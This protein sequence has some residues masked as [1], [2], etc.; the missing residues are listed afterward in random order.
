MENVTEV[1]QKMRNRATIESNNSNISQGNEIT[2]SKRYLHPP[3]HHV[4]RKVLFIIAKTQ[5]QPTF[6]SADDWKKKMWGMRIQWN[7]VQ[8]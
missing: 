3:P 2:K 8:S 5:K 1:P 7:T 4:Q 6:P